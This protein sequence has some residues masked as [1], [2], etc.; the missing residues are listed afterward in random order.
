M[1]AKIKSQRKSKANRRAR[2]RAWLIALTALGCSAIVAAPNVAQSANEEGG[3]YFRLTVKLTYKGEPEDF[4]VVVG[5]SVPAHHYDNITYYVMV[6]SAFGRKMSDGKVV[7]VR[8]PRACDGETTANGGVQPDLLPLIVVYD[9]AET[10]AFGTAYLS[11]DAYESPLSVLK[12][13]G[14]TI[15]TARRAEFDEFRRTQ[16][17]A[18]T[19]AIFWSNSAADD[20]LKRM[21]L[22]I[23]ANAFGNICDYY[24]RYRL[25]DELR[26][27]LRQH[28]PAERPNYWI[29]NSF[30]DEQKLLRLIQ[31]NHNLQ[32][33]DSR[34][35]PR[36]YPISTGNPDVGFPTRA[37]GGMI[38]TTRGERF[39]GAYY[40][41]TYDDRPDKWPVDQ[42]DKARYFGTHETFDYVDV[43]FRARLTKGFA[44]C[45]SHHLNFDR[46]LLLTKLT[47]ARVGTEAIWANPSLH[48]TGTALPIAFFERDEF[49]FIHKRTG[50]G[51]DRGDVW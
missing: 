44:Y 10:L 46:S 24:M 23:L 35:P 20:V 34:D 22:P 30:E 11:E 31:E 47:V 29:A 8:P 50:V 40:P 27:V 49:L 9:D 32:S 38:S 26:A 43:D 21:G 5:C 19:R 45:G 42:A 37:G 13:G 36:G 28:W 6:P 4:D 14:A 39:A 15:E 7:V 2:G 51:P 48:L 16:K 3:P 25:P 1:T 12:F 41:A 33:D 17:N 18:V